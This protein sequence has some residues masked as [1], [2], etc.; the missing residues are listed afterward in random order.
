MGSFKN[1]EF[2]NMKFLF[3][4]KPKIKRGYELK[5]N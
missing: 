5:G 4:T 1:F 3:Q 2:K